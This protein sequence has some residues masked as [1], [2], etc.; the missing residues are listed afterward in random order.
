PGGAEISRSLDSLVALFD[1][2]KRFVER[3]PQEKPALFI[4]D[5]PDS[6]VP[7]DTLSTPDRPGLVTLMTP[8]SA[9]GAEFEAVVVAG[10]QDGIWPNVRLRGGMLETW[11][12]AESLTALRTGQPETVPGILDRRR[13]A[14]HDELRLFV[15][16]VSRARTRLVVTAVG[17][18]DMSPSPFFAFL[19]DPLPAE[20]DEQRFAHPLTLRGLVARHRRTLTVA[21]DEAEL[22]EAAGQLRLLAEAGVPGAAPEDWYGITEP[23]TTAPLRDLQSGP[24]RV[25]TSRL[26]AF[27]E[28]GLNWVI[29]SLGGDTVA[30]PSAGIGTI[31]HEAMEKVPDGDIEAMK[32]IVD[33]HWPELRSEE[34]TS[35]L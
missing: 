17:D 18:D 16:A 33:E 30:P 31:V 2:A 6:E 8:A 3:S 25:S 5:L 22:A 34:H 4:R 28:C 13:A 20:D 14:L 19:P 23:S 24:V 10:V 15:R 11:R 29:S 35:E 12:L 27:E 21:T 9:L 1:A 26:E 32:A 7:E